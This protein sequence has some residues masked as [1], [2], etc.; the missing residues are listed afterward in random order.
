M[1]VFR[2]T[3]RFAFVTPNARFHENEIPG[4]NFIAPPQATIN[5][6]DPCLTE[7]QKFS[8]RI[9]LRPRT[10]TRDTAQTSRPTFIPP[11]RRL[12]FEHGLQPESK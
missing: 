10:P 3:R 12:A 4:P 2:D 8:Q 9:N 5:I 1:P 6:A 11:I 7:A